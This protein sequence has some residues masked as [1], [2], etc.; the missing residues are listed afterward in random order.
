VVLVTLYGVNLANNFA[1]SINEDM[2]K[3]RSTPMIDPW[4]SLL[5]PDWLVGSVV[6]PV[7]FF[8]AAAAGLRG[9]DA[10]LAATRNALV[11]QVFSIGCVS[12]AGS[13]AATSGAHGCPASW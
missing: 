12:P 9:R 8:G 2:A 5:R 10:A 6:I 13:A 3:R 11:L 4:R 1:M 7:V